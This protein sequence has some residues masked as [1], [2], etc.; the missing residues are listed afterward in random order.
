VLG[1]ALV[2]VTQAGI[3]HLSFDED[4]RAL[5]QRFPN[6][7]LT[8][9]CGAL[10]TLSAQAVA[11]VNAPHLPA[12]LPLDPGGTAFQRKVWQ[13]LLAIPPGETRTYKQIS[14]QI[15]HPGAAR[16]VGTANGANPVA[17]LIPC[18][19]LIRGDGALGG[20]AYG[21]DR[22]TQLLNMEAQSS[23]EPI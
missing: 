1:S 15:D 3:C 18:H 19:R 21:L 17:V 23:G 2:A 7:Q 13:A 5:A 16:A 8:A 6:A 9:A 10:A 22:K 4:Q 20:Y 11:A 14:E 12:P